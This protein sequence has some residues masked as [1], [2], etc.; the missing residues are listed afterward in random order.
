MRRGDERPSS[1]DG[2]VVDA[3]DRVIHGRISRAQFMKRAAALGLA[4]PAVSAV[5]AAC[6]S[7]DGG[8]GGSTGGGGS[9]SAVQSIV[10]PDGIDGIADFNGPYGPTTAAVLPAD[11]HGPVDADGIWQW[12]FLDFK[13]DKPYRLAFAHFSSKWDLSVELTA[14][15][16]RAAQKIGVSL[17]SFDNNFDADTAIRNA[18]LIVQ[19]KFDYAIIAQIF[20]DANEAIFK[21]LDAAGIGSSYLAVEAADEP[22]SSFFDPGNYRMCRELGV[23]LGNYAKDNWDGNVDLV[24]LGAQPRAGKYVAE[25]EV[26][27]KAGIQSVLPDVPDSAFKTIDSQGLLEEAQKKTADLLTNNPNAKYILGCGTN[28]DV[29][30]G[31]TRALEAAGRAGTAAVAGQ[32]G[33]QSAVDELSKPDSA[34]KVSAF[35]D[36]ESWTWMAAVGVLDLMGGQTSKV[37][38]IPFYITTKENVA[39]FPAQAGALS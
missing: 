28:D 26:G 7:D 20:P 32:A 22:E 23:W 15:F 33:Q 14:R 35:Q 24:V 12:D 19:Q 1:I 39:D 30:V 6:G 11:Y 37:N 16:E 29:G 2:E 13:A 36:T 18:D 10:Y 4:V 5:L 8:A 27:Y 25:R 38:L 34:F 3:V 9:A 31:I 21:K 17:E